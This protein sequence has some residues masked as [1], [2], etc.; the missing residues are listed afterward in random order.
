M[1][2]KLTKHQLRML[3]S[4]EKQK[5]E[6][7]KLYDEIVDAEQELLAMAIK[8]ADLPT[9]AYQLKQSGNDIVIFSESNPVAEGNTLGEE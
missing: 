5:E 2:H 6:A 4:L 8:Y 1:E 9:G 7:K 3:L